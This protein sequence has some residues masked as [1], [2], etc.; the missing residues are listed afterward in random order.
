MMCYREFVNLLTVVVVLAASAL[1]SELTFELPDNAKECFHEV[2]RKGVK[3]TLEFQVRYYDLIVHV[4]SFC[5]QIGLDQISIRNYYSL[6]L[7]R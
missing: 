2:I 4:S 3:A 1:A 7:R 6:S 5:F